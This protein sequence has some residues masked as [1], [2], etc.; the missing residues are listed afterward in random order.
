MNSIKDLPSSGTVFYQIE[1]L[2]TAEADQ[3]RE[4][5]REYLGYPVYWWADLDGGRH[6][7][8]LPVACVRILY[9]D[10]YLVAGFIIE[11]SQR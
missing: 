2:S 8:P 11:G 9:R 7:W 5:V 10:S 3:I 6:F 4:D 1:Q